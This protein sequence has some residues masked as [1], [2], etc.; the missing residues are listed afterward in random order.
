LLDPPVL[1]PAP[2]EPVPSTEFA[3]A[4]MD[5]STPTS[6]FL[7]ALLATAPLED[8]APSVLITALH[9]QDRPLH[10]LAASTAMP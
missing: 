2:L 6:V 1:L 7:P 4:I 3:S 10:A 8:S 5:T 9:A